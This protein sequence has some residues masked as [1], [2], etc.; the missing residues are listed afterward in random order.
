MDPA[1]RAKTASVLAK[2]EEWAM[3][4]ATALGL[5]MTLDRTRRLG[6][7]SFVCDALILFILMKL[8]K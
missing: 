5:S 1:G 7:Q 8:E 6:R 2:T 3:C 4:M